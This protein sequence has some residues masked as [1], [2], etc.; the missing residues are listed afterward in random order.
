MGHVILGSC[1]VTLDSCHILLTE[2]RRAPIPDSNPMSPYCQWI[3]LSGPTLDPLNPD[4]SQVEFTTEE[5][6]SPCL[7]HH[8]ESCQTDEVVVVLHIALW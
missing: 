8:W 5:G 2:T 7:N 4:N 1:H 3:A 6:F